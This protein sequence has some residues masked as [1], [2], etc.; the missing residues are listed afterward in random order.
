MI[1]GTYETLVDVVCGPSSVS[2]MLGGRHGL[3]P[4]TTVGGVVA[5]NLHIF[6]HGFKC[7]GVANHQ[8]IR[9]QFNA[10]GPEL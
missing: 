3:E 8:L 5:Q 2:D 9:I 4:M 7:Y 6:V 1:S 10:I